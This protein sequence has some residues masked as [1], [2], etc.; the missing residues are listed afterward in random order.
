M[1]QLDS[2]RALTNE[3][4][5]EYLCG[6]A[7]QSGQHQLQQWI[8]RRVFFFVFPRAA[9]NLCQLET[10]WTTLRRLSLL[11]LLSSGEMALPQKNRQ[12]GLDIQIT[13]C[14][15]VFWVFYGCQ[16]YLQRRFECR[17][18]ANVWEFFCL[19]HVWSITWLVLL[20]QCL[21]VSDQWLVYIEMVSNACHEQSHLFGMPMSKCTILELQ[22]PKPSFSRGALDVTSFWIILKETTELRLWSLTLT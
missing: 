15:R 16:N 8:N 2:P 20:G 22:Y 4:V 18:L 17:G 12:D 13:S 7:L 3:K 11:G 6:S 14:G 19:Y 9:F 1:L 21:E 10:P 5:A